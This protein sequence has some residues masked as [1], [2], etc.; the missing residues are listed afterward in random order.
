[1]LLI[2]RS[3]DGLSLLWSLVIL[4]RDLSHSL[5]HNLDVFISYFRLFNHKFDFLSLFLHFISLFFDFLSYDLSRSPRDFPFSLV[6][7]WSFTE[8]LFL[9]HTVNMFLY[10]ASALSCKQTVYQLVSSQSPVQIH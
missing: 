5:F 2:N 9:H 7:C 10:E 6:T 8:I 3:L 1:M 4:I